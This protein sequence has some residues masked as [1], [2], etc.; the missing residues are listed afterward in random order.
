MT[1]NEIARLNEVAAT[2]RKTYDEGGVNAL[3]RLFIHNWSEKREYKNGEFMQIGIPCMDVDIWHDGDLISSIDDR[4][5][6]KLDAE[7]T[8]AVVRASYDVPSNIDRYPFLFVEPGIISAKDME[9]IY[10]TWDWF[11]CN[12]S[13][14]LTA[15]NY[16]RWMRDEGLLD[17]DFFELRLDNPE[18]EHFLK[19]SGFND[20]FEDFLDKEIELMNVQIFERLL[21]AIEQIADA[22]RFYW[23]DY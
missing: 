7:L 11:A 17:R 10:T 9:V 16:T 20:R 21:P 22:I 13:E 14:E 15:E 18:F 23:E 12:T 3:R 2:L 5:Y 1:D 19:S 4:A 8:D 6:I